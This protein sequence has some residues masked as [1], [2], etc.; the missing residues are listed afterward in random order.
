MASTEI[1][2]RITAKLPMAWRHH[3]GTLNSGSWPTDDRRSFCNG[4]RCDVR[5]SEVEARYLLVEPTP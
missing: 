5:T 4:C 1:T 3:C 2:V